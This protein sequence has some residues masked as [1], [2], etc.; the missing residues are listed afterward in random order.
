MPPS[1]ALFLCSIVLLI[2]AG[3]LL[4]IPRVEKNQKVFTQFGERVSYGFS[5]VFFIL[6]ASFMV[7][8]ILNLIPEPT[9]WH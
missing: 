6:A 8:A 2:G 4:I 3:I 5:L 9:L 7:M 1:L